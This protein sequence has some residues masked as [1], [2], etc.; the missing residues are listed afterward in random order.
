MKKSIKQVST[1]LLC[2][3]ALGLPTRSA[4]AMQVNG[5]TAFYSIVSSAMSPVLLSS[6]S[7]QSLMTRSSEAF[8]G[9]VSFLR[10][11]AS[12]VAVSAMA[13]QTDLST[14]DLAYIP[15][16]ISKPTAPA[17]RKSSPMQRREAVFGSV[18]FSLKRLAA[19]QSLAPSLAEIETGGFLDCKTNCTAAQKRLSATIAE[20]AQASVR[21]KLNRINRVINNSIGYTRDIDLYN[22]TDRWAKPSETLSRQR[23]DCED[24]AILK[25]AALNAAGLS[26]KDMGVVVLFDQRRRVYHA[27]LSVA[28]AD[29]YFILDNVRDAVLVDKKLPDYMP[30]FSLVDGKAFFH[31]TRV[32]AKSKLT[33]KLLP[34]EKVAP[35][36]GPEGL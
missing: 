7:A 29:N 23:G 31:G 33:A 3:F 12:A 21:D 8:D 22:V 26:M 16:P 9:A 32:G 5:Y 25:M 13:P 4:N 28:V 18:A 15:T 2:V 24:Y 14:V 35:G 1:A 11:K 17:L 30:L 20:T 36:E 19:S 27:V 10:E 34:L 6:F